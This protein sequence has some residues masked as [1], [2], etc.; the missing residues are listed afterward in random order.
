MGKAG[1]CPPLRGIGALLPWSWEL[2]GDEKSVKAR[3][4]WVLEN[5]V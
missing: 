4:M 3:E 2:G 5:V 1:A